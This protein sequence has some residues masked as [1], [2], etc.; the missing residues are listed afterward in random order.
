MLLSLT[1]QMV[2][3][4]DHVRHTGVLKENGGHIG[5]PNHSSGN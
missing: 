5:V 2:K 3:I 1:V 4:S